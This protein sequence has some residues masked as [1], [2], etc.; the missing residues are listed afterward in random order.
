MGDDAFTTGINSVVSSKYNIS[1]AN[2][3]IVIDNCNPTILKR[4]Y[5][6]TGSIIYNGYAD[7]INVNKTG[8]FILRIGNDTFKIMIQN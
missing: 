5:D 8:L 6:V 7:R 2:K 1:V 4:L 3:S